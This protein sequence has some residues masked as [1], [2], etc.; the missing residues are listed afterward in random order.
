MKV[1]KKHNIYIYIKCHHLQTN[2]RKETKILK[3]IFSSVAGCRRHQI[4]MNGEIVHDYLQTCT[5]AKLLNNSQYFKGRHFHFN[6]YKLL[7][8][9]SNNI[10]E[11]SVPLYISRIPLDKLT[12]YLNMKEL[13]H[14]SDLHNIP[15]PRC[16]EKRQC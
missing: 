13:Q 4:S 7:S 14:M 6:E 11:S 3:V 8:A 10:L 2:L 16:I 12:M 5:D 15:M 9:T 1:R